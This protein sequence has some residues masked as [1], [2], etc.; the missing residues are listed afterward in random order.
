MWLGMGTACGG[1]FLGALLG[2]LTRGK[3]PQRC[4]DPTCYRNG[5]VHGK[6]HYHDVGAP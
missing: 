6:S 4:D 1:A 2:G 3:R 5:Q